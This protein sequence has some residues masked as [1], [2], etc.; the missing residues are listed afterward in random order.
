MAGHAAGMARDVLSGFV[1]D[2]G[3]ARGRPVGLAVDAA[4]ALLVADDVGN[5]IWR[6]TSQ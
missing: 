4:G 3:D 5:A 2:N 1:D 6:V